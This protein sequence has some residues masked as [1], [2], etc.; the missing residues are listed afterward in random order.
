MNESK[1]VVRVSMI[2]KYS[3]EMTTHNIMD[4]MKAIMTAKT[5][6]ILDRIDKIVSIFG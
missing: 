5:A 1:A 6:G 3:G 2:R 4:R